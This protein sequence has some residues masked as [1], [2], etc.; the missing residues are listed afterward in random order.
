MRKA[1]MGIGSFLIVVGIV[2][3]VMSLVAVSAITPHLDQADAVIADATG[4][5]RGT[6]ST[7]RDVAAEL[8][9]VETSLADL[10][11]AVDELDVDWVETGLA[12]LQ[13]MVGEL[14]DD[15]VTARVEAVAT[16]AEL[17]IVVTAD[18]LDYVAE[19]IEELGLDATPLRDLA[20][21]LRQEGLAIAIDEELVSHNF[22]RVI[23][24]VDAASDGLSSAQGVVPTAMEA[25]EA[26]SSGLTSAKGVISTTKTGLGDLA[27]SMDDMAGGIERIDIG[28]MVKESVGFLRI[29]LVFTSILFMASGAGLLLVGIKME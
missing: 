12:D 26:A 6:G 11:Q 21:S 2:V 15:L 22:G 23:E 1:V 25:M 3:L 8:S 9:G 28:G 29:F 7:L 20:A 13:Q 19:A 16:L 5:V 27:A 14:R 24:A 10:Q 4:A 17:D 18:D